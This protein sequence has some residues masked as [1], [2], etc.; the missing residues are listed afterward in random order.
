MPT[1]E[2]RLLRGRRR[3][4]ELV[5]RRIAELRQLR[6]SLGVGQTQ[7]AGALSCSVSQLWRLE[8]GDV[9]AVTVTRLAEMASVLGHEISLGLHPIGDPIR[10]KGQ[11]ALAHRFDAL[12]SE[13]WQSTSEVLLPLTGDRRAWDKLLR[14]VGNDYR[15]GVDLETRIRDIQEL[16]RRTR[17]RERDG[18][19]DAI[20]IV[21]SDSSTN[22]RLVD[23]LR[24]TL[25]RDYTTSPR[26]ILAVLRG[27]RRLAG[28]GVVVI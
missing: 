16:T 2:T 10:D 25:G 6:L 5:R 12:L 18:G 7:M 13:A 17:L 9:G 27:G 24:V 15:V 20:L 22:R 8:A 19:V 11:Q 3:G 23:E 1:R 14:L 4:R 26:S 21:L 28:S